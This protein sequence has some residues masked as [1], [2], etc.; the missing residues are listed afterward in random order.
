MLAEWIVG[1][2]IIADNDLPQRVT[3]SHSPPWD[4]YVGRY[5]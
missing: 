1:S 3:V 5:R 4:R 2:T